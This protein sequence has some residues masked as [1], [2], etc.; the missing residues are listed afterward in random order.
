MTTIRYT[1]TLFY[2]DGIQLFQATDAIGG[3]YVAMMI[4]ASGHGNRH[5]VVGVA[6]SELHRFCSGQ[7]DLCSL[8]LQ[9]GNKEWYTTTV[10]DD[11]EADLVLERQR[12]PLLQSGLLPDDG[13]VLPHSPTGTVLIEE[14]RKRNNLLF[15]LVTHPPESALA[16][17]IRVNTIGS[18]LIRLQKLVQHAY[19]RA[20]RNAPRSTKSMADMAQGYLMD[21]V[22]PAVGGSFGVLLEGAVLADTTRDL[23]GHSELARALA[24]VDDLFQHVGNPE[25]CI[26]VVAANRGRLGST[27]VN[28]LRF[29]VEHDT[30]LQYA[31]A[32]PTFVRPRYGAVSRAEAVSLVDAFSKVSGIS[33]EPV[34]VIGE[35]NRFNRKSGIWGLVG[36]DRHYS[37]KIREGGPSMDGLKVGGR[38][39]FGCIEETEEVDATG[40]QRQTL[41]LNWHEPA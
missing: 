1:R 35:F 29:L 13:F 26:K 20:L 36:E 27:Y 16:N 12:A 41:F 14:A 8:M 21:V 3:H 19:A 18:I 17:R 10:A 11:L 30:D 7:L 37:G 39:K 31:W 2:Y 33:S 4:D 9:I 28:L 15:E 23:F 25:Q 34:T 5:L 22:V 24:L 6:P 38:Y 40:V 32:E